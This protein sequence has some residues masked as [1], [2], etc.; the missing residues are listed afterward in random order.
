[1][2]RCRFQAIWKVWYRLRYCD[3]PTLAAL[4]SYHARR[5]EFSMSKIFICGQMQDHARQPRGSLLHS[6]QLSASTHLPNRTRI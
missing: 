4:K 3:E 5:F 6:Y 1:M 2:S